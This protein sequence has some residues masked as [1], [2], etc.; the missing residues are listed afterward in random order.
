[1]ISISCSKN[2]KSSET[3]AQPDKQ[4]QSTVVSQQS[5]VQDTVQDRNSKHATVLDFYATWC[6]PCKEMTPIVEEMEKK[7]NG[8]I[9]FKSIDIDKEPELADK[10]QINCVPTFVIVTEYGVLDQISGSMP[11]EEFEEFIKKAL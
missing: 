8:K 6:G 10:Y 11:E 4:M 2:G 5:T 3:S 7:Y 1:M 9:E